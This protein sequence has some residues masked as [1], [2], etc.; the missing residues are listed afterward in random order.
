MEK[1]GEIIGSI[2]YSK[3]K[4]KSDDGNVTD[5]IC[6]GPVGIKPDFQDTGLGKKLIGYSLKEAEKLGYTAVFITGK[7]TYYNKFGFESASKYGVFLDDNR[8][9]EFK[10][11]MVRLSEEDALSGMSGILEFS[12]CFDPSKEETEEFDKMFQPK[13]KEKR[14]GQIWK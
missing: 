2:I 4:L 12:D 6:F 1:E 11:F 8:E 3:A 5:F 13:L 7:H 9:G 10:S 14:P